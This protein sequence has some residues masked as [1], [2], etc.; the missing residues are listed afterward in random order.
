MGLPAGLP[1]LIEKPEALA[2]RGCIVFGFPARVSDVPHVTLPGGYSGQGITTEIQ[3]HRYGAI[4]PIREKYG[5]N[6]VKIREKREK[7]RKTCVKFMFA[8]GLTVH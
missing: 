5:K 1:S 4:P 6:S 8:T 2:G 7:I 3:H